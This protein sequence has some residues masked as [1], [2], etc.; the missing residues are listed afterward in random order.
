MQKSLS[1]S[2]FG[3]IR[4]PVQTQP[5]RLTSM[6]GNDSLN[7][8]AKAVVA[9][10]CYG[11]FGVNFVIYIGRSAT[12]THSELVPKIALVKLIDRHDVVCNRASAITSP[13]VQIV[14]GVATV[15]QKS[16]SIDR[17]DNI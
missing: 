7:G 16:F 5:Y 8:S 9:G 1:T 17:A 10:T 13:L 4:K 14:G 11:K 3:G 6:A 15:N 2:N 12:V